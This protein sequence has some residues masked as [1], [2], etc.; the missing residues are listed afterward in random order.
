M[1]SIVEGTE[2]KSLTKKYCTFHTTNYSFVG[3]MNGQVK[4]FLIVDD[5]VIVT[6]NSRIPMGGRAY[7]NTD[8]VVA[9][10]PNNE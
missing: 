1:S 5:G 6:D 2:F 3:M 10:I 7:I 4:G 9:I 8:H